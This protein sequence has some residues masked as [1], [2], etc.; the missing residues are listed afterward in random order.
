MIQTIGVIG[1]GQM[2]SGIAETF[3]TVGY[4]VILHDL[5]KD[6]LKLGIEGIERNLIR[7]VSRKKLSEEEQKEAIEK[8]KGT[9]SFKD[10]KSCDLVIEAATEDEGIKKAI[11]R[12]VN[13]HLSP[14]C[15]IASN[16]SSISITLLASVTDRPERV[17]GM[18]FM[19][20]APVM[21]LV[22]VIRGLGTSDETYKTIVDIVKKLG[23][24]TALSQDFPGFIVNRILMPMINEAC[25]ALYEGV[26][27]IR[28]IDRGMKLGT[29][30]PMGPFE[31][32]DL[33]GL[34]TCCSIMSV[35]HKGLNGSK[36]QPCPLLVQYVNAGWLGRKTKKGFYDYS[37][38][39]PV[40]T[41]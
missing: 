18:H 11:L 26:G 28:A 16:T 22:E 1:A 39:D 3:A 21:Q 30:H 24:K 40:P 10:F 32:A 33:I 20:P 25:Y 5:E 38:E 27:T 36:Y 19:N 35:L 12:E 15:I 7:Q 6:R 4:S 9:T 17:I 41:R 34:D 2:G 29:N 13:P 37:G 23:K 14:S 31:L 8:I